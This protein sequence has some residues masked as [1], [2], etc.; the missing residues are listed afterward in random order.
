MLW[1]VFLLQTYAHCSLILLKCQ[2]KI[3]KPLGPT[4]C[5]LFPF[6][7]PTVQE[8][9]CPKRQASLNSPTSGSASAMNAQHAIECDIWNMC[10]VMVE[11]SVLSWEQR[12]NDLLN[13]R[14]F[15]LFQGLI[16]QGLYCYIYIFFHGNMNIYNCPIQLCSVITVHLLKNK[17]AK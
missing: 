17:F 13:K 3:L 12:E 11:I 4:Y 10:F 9:D 6:Y 8:V 7:F 5:L 2:H 15:V 16:A 1:S 14:F